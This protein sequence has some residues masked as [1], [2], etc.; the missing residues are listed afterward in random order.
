MKLSLYFLVPTFLLWAG[1]QSTPSTP[2]LGG[3]EGFSGC[4]SSLTYGGGSQKYRFVADVLEKPSPQYS[5]CKGDIENCVYTAHR[6][7]Y[8]MNGYK[9]EYTPFQLQPH[10]DQYTLQTV[11]TFAGVFQNI[12]QNFTTGI[13]IKSLELIPNVYMGIYVVLGGFNLRTASV[14]ENGFITYYSAG[15]QS[16]GTPSG[17]N[18][19]QIYVELGA[20]IT[21][22]W[23]VEGDRIGRL[24]FRVTPPNPNAEPRQYTFEGSPFG[25][26]F[27]AT[28]APAITGP[29]DLLSIGGQTTNDLGG[30][31]NALE[32]T[33]ACVGKP[34]HYTY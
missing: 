15:N 22:V 29:C 30:F 3:E 12:Q 24:N 33:W 17:P 8:C 32:F 11:K 7:Y 2:S 4:P 1:G 20:G 26:P 28:P 6:K 25:V 5:P 21:E 27:D 16:I 14:P 10:H 31:I 19:T 23:G 13:Y 9:P 18:P 34:S